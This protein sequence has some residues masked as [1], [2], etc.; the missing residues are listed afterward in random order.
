MGILLFLTPI[1]F[2]TPHAQSAHIIFD[3][4]GVLI[5]SNY[6]QALDQFGLTKMDFVWYMLTTGNNPRTRLFQLF[7]TIK[8]RDPHEAPTCDENGSLLPQLMLDWQRG[9]AAPEVI[10]DTMLEYCT[11]HPELMHS[12]LEKKIFTRMISTMFTP[13]RFA[14]MQQWDSE[15]LAL[16]HECKK[17]GHTLYILSNWDAGTFAAMY[18]QPYFKT[19]FDLFDGI[20]LSGAV[21]MIKPEPTIYQ[22]LL[23]TYKLDPTQ[24][25]FIDDQLVN[26]RAARTVGIY[27]IWC[28][29]VRSLLCPWST[30]PDFAYVRSR[31][32]TREQA[33][34]A[35]IPR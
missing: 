27:S 35:A 28:R 15:A 10:R 25:V 14:A 20:I 2:F 18:A 1:L 4:N 11:T 17:L 29:P 6:E 12:E 26:V 8:P 30:W 33:L 9:A 24:C 31:L 5:N 23:D 22:H 16:V 34:L 19:V 3:L 13:E 21:H 7:D 32:A